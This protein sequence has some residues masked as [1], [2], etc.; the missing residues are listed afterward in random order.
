MYEEITFTNGDDYFQAVKDAIS[1]AKNFIHIESYIFD[2]DSLGLDI[3]ELLVKAKER[4][5]RVQ[6]LLDGVGS[7][8][9]SFADAQ[10]W[11]GLGVELKFFHALPWQR[12][13]STVWKLLTLKRIAL[14]FFKLN[15]RNH[16][17]ICIIDNN[18]I[19]VSSMNISERH[20]P[21]VRGNQA[22][23]DVSVMIRGGNL[24]SFLTMARDA[25][26]FSQEHYG[27]RW[28][29]ISRQKKAEHSELIR[30]IR[31]AK[32]KIWITNPYF[33][34]D[35]HLTRQ[36]CAA[37]WRGVD[38]KILLPGFSDVIGAKFAMESYYNALLTF[39]IK[40][41]EYKP[42]LLHAKVLIIDNW[43]SMGSYNLDYR[44][45]FYNLET[46]ATLVLQSNIEKAQD[47]FIM[48]IQSSR[49]IELAEWTQR[50]WMHRL[51]EKFFLSFQG[52]L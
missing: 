46:N 32:S 27:Y 20:L 40:V 18:T 12:R 19:F 22:L 43:V 51:L 38:V 29:K 17:K 25:W 2:Q 3:L 33:I 44:S 28:R 26:N 13:P 8:A 49:K 41:Y 45:I 42:T 36:L 14:G 31:Q 50:S 37:A 16:R 35:L 6:L 39:G 34:P 52:W 11:R 5:V 23:K 4:G 21:S 7:S 30:N 10:R 48:D 47:Q 9:W 1:S 24:E 15:R